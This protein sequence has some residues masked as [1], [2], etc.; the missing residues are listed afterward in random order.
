MSEKIFIDGMIVKNAKPSFVKC[1]LSF[2]V[3][4]FGA[5]LL[6]HE[7][8]GWVNIDV[9]ESKNGKLYAELDTWKKDQKQEPEPQETPDYGVGD[10][11]PF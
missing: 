7:K 8:D 3:D 2:K 6:Q 10:D 9:K 4:K 1:R 5:F 11:A